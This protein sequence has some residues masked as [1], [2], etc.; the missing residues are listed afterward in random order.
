M[1]LR[2]GAPDYPTIF[3]K[4]PVKDQTREQLRQRALNQSQS[5]ICIDTGLGSTANT[6]IPENAGIQGTAENAFS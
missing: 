3:T 6:V 2:W 4:H 5:G 1:S